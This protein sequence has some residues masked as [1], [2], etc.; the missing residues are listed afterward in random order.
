MIMKNMI[1][2][3]QNHMTKFDAWF[4]RK[5]PPKR[6]VRSSSRPRSIPDVED[7]PR[8]EERNEREPSLR[9]SHSLRD[10]GSNHHESMS[11]QE[12]AFMRSHSYRAPCGTNSILGRF[13]EEDIGKIGEPPI[14]LRPPKPMFA[15][16]SSSEVKNRVPNPLELNQIF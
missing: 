7:D 4:E 11:H 16:R 10:R 9:R 3:V 15:K 8:E 14:I 2:V 5:E 6:N 13:L 1:E 12:H